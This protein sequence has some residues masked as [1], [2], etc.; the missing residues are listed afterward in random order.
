MQI[1]QF[2]AAAVGC[3]FRFHAMLF[4]NDKTCY[5]FPVLFVLIFLAHS[6]SL[7]FLFLNYFFQEYILKRNQK[8]R[9]PKLNI[10]K[11]KN[12]YIKTAKDE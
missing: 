6:I 3:T 12:G 2:I 7:L 10:I 1:S 5:D 11:T 8:R 4:K 9:E